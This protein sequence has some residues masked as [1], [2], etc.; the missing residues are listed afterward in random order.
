[1][2]DLFPVLPCG[3]VTV[4][5][6]SDKPV[7]VHPANVYPVFVGLFNVIAALSTVYVSGF[8]VDTAPP[9]SEYEIVYVSAVLSDV[10]VTV[11]FAA[12]IVIVVVFELALAIS[13]VF[14]VAVH[15]KFEYVYPTVSVVSAD[16]ATVCPHL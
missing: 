14:G 10:A 12:G 3:I 4:V 5:V 2:Y 8:A 11:V 15:A 6:A 16:I 13:A 1:M 9:S 7:P